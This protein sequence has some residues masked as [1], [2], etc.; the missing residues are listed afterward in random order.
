MELV[1]G[2][3]TQPTTET[4]TDTHW[5]TDTLMD[6]DTLSSLPW[7]SCD[8]STV[9]FLY[10]LYFV[11]AALL[12]NLKFRKSSVH[13][14][15]GRGGFRDV[16]FPGTSILALQPHCRVLPPGE[17]N[18]VIIV[19]VTAWCWQSQ[20]LRPSVR[21]T[22]TFTRRY[23]VERAKRRPIIKLFHDRVATPYSSFPH[24]T[25]YLPNGGGE[26]VGYK[27]IAIFDQYFDLSRKWYNIEL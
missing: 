8:V 26:C 18:G 22:V 24:Q 14:L 23:R 21:R 6:S 2:I 7:P 1:Q 17:F 19:I 16:R 4:D 10:T 20:D 11:A 27:T 3:E 15:V 12:P 13:Q 25:W 9:Q 5:H